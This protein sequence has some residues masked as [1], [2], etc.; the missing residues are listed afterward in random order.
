MNRRSFLQT[1]KKIGAA[2]VAFSILT[3]ARSARATPAND[4]I[5][6]AMVGVGGRGS[7][8]AMGFLERDDCQ[9]THI[10]DVD[11]TKAVNRAKEIG[12]Y[13]TGLQPTCVQDVRE[14]L[15]DASVDAVVIAT[16]DHWH[17]LAA[18]WACQAGKDVYV[19]KP[20]SHNPWEA[21]QLF[22]A[23]RGSNR[24]VQV[25]TQSRSAPYMMEAMR[26]IDRGALGKIHLCRV[27]NMKHQS[28]FLLPPDAETPA[29]LDWDAWCGPAPL[30]PYNAGVQHPYW[31]HFWDFSGG[32]AANDAVHQLD[33]ARWLVGQ[34]APKSVYCTGGRYQS[35]GSAQTP[36]TQ[37]AIY[38]FGDLVMTFDLT[39]FTPYMLKTDRGIRDGDLFPYWLQNATRIELYGSEAMMIVGR[40]GGGWQIYTRPKARQP[41]V[42][43]SQFGRFPDPEHKENFLQC[44]RTREIPNADVREGMFSD[45]LYQLANI[46]YRLGGRKLTVNQEDLTIEDDEEAMKLYQRS[47]RSPWTFEVS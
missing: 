44:M 8:L 12:S 16:P 4:K 41:V 11:R 32:D 3:D 47:Y 26:Q 46:S 36:D 14:V 19:E 20:M 38:E 40:L 31:H 27:F 6:L 34:D 9:I 25:G 30:R 35:E 39:L 22:K 17:S 23:A 33:L 1:S 18:I 45:L 37:T 21:Q 5:N 2:S 15:Q 13:R 42:K 7:A 10:C 29:G 43:A 24:I 28:N